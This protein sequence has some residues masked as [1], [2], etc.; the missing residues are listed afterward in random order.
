MP[1]PPAGSCGR[2]APGGA[3]LEE[4]DSSCQGLCRAAS[5]TTRSDDTAPLAA[6][7]LTGGPEGMELLT[8]AVGMRCAVILVQCITHTR[9]RWSPAELQRGGHAHCGSRLVH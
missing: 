6:P 9:A 2:A 8:L 3:G 5:P 4:S 1:R 7:A